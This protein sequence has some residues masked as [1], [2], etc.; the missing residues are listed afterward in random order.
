MTMRAT[1]SPADP[2]QPANRGLVDPLGHVGDDVLEVAAVPGTRPR[3]RHHLGAH[4]LTAPTVEPADLGLQPQLRPGQIQVSPTT[5][6]AVIDRPGRP[7]ARAHQPG[8]PSPQADHD[9]RWRERHRRHRGP[10]DPQHLVE[11]STDA[12]ALI[13]PRSIALEAP[14]VGAGHVRVTQAQQARK[15]RPKPPG[16]N[17]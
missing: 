11:C 6:R 12:H 16:L 4:P 8:S 3:P 10:D 1:A 14:N 7:P 13:P 5:R 2:Q 17:S 9:P 15:A